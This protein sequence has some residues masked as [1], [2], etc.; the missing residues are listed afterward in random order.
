MHVTRARA[1]RNVG[2]RY[3]RPPRRAGSRAL[4]AL[5]AFGLAVLSAPVLGT[6]PAH[7]AGK[8]VLRVALTQ[9]VDSL[10]PYLSITSAGTEMGR[11]MYEFMTTNA[12]KDNHPVP[13]LA[14]SW[15]HSKNGL[16]WTFTI[17]DGAKWSDG[18]PITAHDV[19]YTYN[20]MLQDPTAAT[21]NGNF[22]TNFKTVTAPDDHT[23]VIKT[24]SPQAT[25]TDLD[26][27]ILPKHVWQDV[28]A[29]K[30]GTFKNEQPNAVGSGPFVLSEFKQ[31]Q[32]VKFKA[33][34]NYWRR[35][36]P[37]ID[38]LDFVHF[39]NAES[40]V[41]ALLK[42][43]VDL[44][45]QGVKL[46]PA[47]FDKLK[48]SDNI[49]V[50]KAKGRRTVDLLLNPGATTNED[51][52]IGDGNPVLKDQRVRDAIADSLDLKTIVKRAYGG[53]AQPGDG[54][55]VPPVFDKYHWSPPQGVRHTF[56]L[57]AANNELAKAGYRRGPN[58]M[59]LDHSGKPIKLRMLGRADRPADPIEADLIKGWLAKIGVGVQ[60]SMVGSN[61][62]NDATTAGNYDLA[63]SGWGANPDP[64]YVLAT[65]TC[66]RRPDASGNGGTSAANW[67]DPAYDKLYAKQL[68]TLDTGKRAKVVKQLQAVAYK[69]APAVTLA[70]PNALE[71]YR[72]DRFQSFQLQPDPGGVI[73]EQNGYWGLYKATPA[74]DPSSGGGNTGLVV[75]IVIAVIVVVGGGGLYLFSRRRKATAE[76]RE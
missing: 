53:Y 54:I 59:R 18:K 65:E 43:S 21:A 71:A 50:N 32:Y 61:R 17:R 29:S 68:S 40:A 69:A 48:S 49:Q 16:T 22:V 46:T 72:S 7:A 6:A 24:K 25:M 33:N 3:G 31:G 42:G 67:C 76:D 36:Q 15:K 19:A 57:A 26:I 30:L 52:P 45:D 35:Q 70:Y 56:D 63:L 27:P 62:L 9:N 34:K 73:T 5:L 13:G 75:G 1:M 58:G 64:D 38:E 51:K 37:K 10:N 39:N 4:L 44:I 8:K 60:V 14:K 28:P 74:A 2:R 11:L 55:I 66:E 20:R 47:Q 23:V 12:A 41:Q